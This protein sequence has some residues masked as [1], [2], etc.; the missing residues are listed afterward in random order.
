VEGSETLVD[1]IGASMRKEWRH[2]EWLLIDLIPRG[3]C[4]RLAVFGIAVGC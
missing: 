3:Y 2:R 4:T 1:T